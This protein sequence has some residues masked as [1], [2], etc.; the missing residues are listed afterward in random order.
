MEIKVEVKKRLEFVD[1][2][3]HCSI[4]LEKDTKVA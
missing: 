3:E 1:P 4:Q 2:E